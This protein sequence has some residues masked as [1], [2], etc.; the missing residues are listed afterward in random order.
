MLD[1]TKIMDNSFAADVLMGLAASQ[2]TIPCRWLYDTRG[3]ELFED[4]T[5][6]PEY[7]P[8][9]T[10]TK[11]LQAR[12][13]AIARL[14]GDGAQ[15]I[16]YGAGASV[17][18]RL[19]LDAMAGLHAYVPI[20]VSASF[21]AETARQLACDYP[22]LN[23]VPVVGDF[24]S[25][26]ELPALGAAGRKVGFFPGS[27]IGNLSDAEIADFFARARQDLGT[28]A[29][30][31]LGA[32]LKKDEAILIPAYDDAAGVTARFNLNLLRRIN[33]ELG[34]TFEL[35]WF[36]HEARW[37]EVCSRVEMH[38]VSLR[39]QTAHVCGKR[40]DFAAG[41]TIHTENS[42]KFAAG[43][44]SKLAA[45]QS[46]RTQETWTDEDGLF[47]VMVLEAG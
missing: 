46:W 3:S 10:E 36:S 44:L 39:D 7:Y 15:L 28:G 19:L 13:D 37:N 1:T 29:L 35:D 5:G 2:K 4:I 9:R 20:D 32:D 38:L 47:S 27:T 41:E 11:I 12:A 14:A 24:L 40:V 25:P 45:K 31:V 23:I 17:K 30:F 16:E 42:R 43:E 34:A 18:T 21:L 22:D 33:R 26:I 8:T 6:L